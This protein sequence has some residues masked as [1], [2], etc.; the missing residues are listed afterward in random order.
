[1]VVL[2]VA[3][4]DDP[5]E[6]ED[7]ERDE[8]GGPHDLLPL[9]VGGVVLMAFHDE[10]D[11]AVVDE[12]LQVLQDHDVLSEQLRELVDPLDGVDGLHPLLEHHRQRVR[13]LS[14]LLVQSLTIRCRN[15]MVSKITGNV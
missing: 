12:L 1:M 10:R 14:N 7:V 4:G 3:D 15:C 9:V 6:E 2:D 8:V 13:L 11:V 5:L